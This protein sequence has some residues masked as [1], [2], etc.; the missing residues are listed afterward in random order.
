MRVDAEN[1]VETSA[2]TAKG[3]ERNNLEDYN[4]SNN[5]KR[6]EVKGSGSDEE[7]SDDEVISGD[8]LE[9]DVKV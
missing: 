9:D 7:N 1:V 6:S 2:G 3:E 8:E 4:D 5:S